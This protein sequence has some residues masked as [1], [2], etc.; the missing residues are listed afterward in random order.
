MLPVQCASTIN[1]RVLDGQYLIVLLML[2]HCGMANSKIKTL[3]KRIRTFREKQCLHLQR[4]PP[5]RPHV[6]EEL[7]C[8]ESLGQR[9]VSSH[10]LNTS[11]YTIWQIFIGNGRWLKGNNPGFFLIAILAFYGRRDVTGLRY[12][13]GKR[14]AAVRVCWS[15]HNWFGALSKGMRS[16]ELIQGWMKNE[17]AYINKLMSE[18]ERTKVQCRGYR[19]QRNWRNV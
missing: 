3:G 11:A 13:W 7:Y 10:A 9:R 1:I 5:M 4:Y 12:G 19:Q 2:Q 18:C 8:C 16:N 17:S 15:S 14:W 6:S